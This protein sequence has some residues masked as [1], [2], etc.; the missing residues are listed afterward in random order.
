MDGFASAERGTR[1]K[2]KSMSMKVLACASTLA[3]ALIGQFAANSDA[4]AD[5][6]PGYD[7]G[8]HPGGHFNRCYPK[9]PAL[10]T[11]LREK[12]PAPRP[13]KPPKLR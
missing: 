4:L 2:E 11:S 9:S 1:S 5:C 10:M 13:P 3:L 6:K 12:I 7:R 8:V